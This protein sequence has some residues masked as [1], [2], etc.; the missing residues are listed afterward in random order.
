MPLVSRL[1]LCRIRILWRCC[2]CVLDCFAARRLDASSEDCDSDDESLLVELLSLSDCEDSSST[3]RADDFF[4]LSLFC[5]FFTILA[6]SSSLSLASSFLA[7]LSLVLCL[8]SC[9][10]LVRCRASCLCWA[11]LSDV[12]SVTVS[13]GS[14]D[15]TWWPCDVII[16]G[17]SSTVSTLTA[18]C[19]LDND[20]AASS[21]PRGSFSSSASVKYWHWQSH[22]LFYALSM[23]HFRTLEFFSKINKC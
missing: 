23:P 9:L 1:L 13:G 7:S 10:S 8:I 4:D 19:C 2:V 5:V 15:V 14:D 20:V 12:L 22:S 17:L 6:L 16:S 3:S 11:S 21:R 18:V